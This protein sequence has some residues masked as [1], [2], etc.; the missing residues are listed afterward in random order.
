M[1]DCSTGKQ[2]NWRRI[3]DPFRGSSIFA[4]VA[5]VLASNAVQFSPATAKWR[6][7]QT[8]HF[9]IFYSQAR[10]LDS[11]AEEA[12][13]AYA[14]VSLDL[15]RQVSAKVPLILLPTK[16]DLPQTEVEAAVIVRSSGAAL[17]RD[18]LLLPVEPRT[19]REKMLA[20]ELTHIFEFDRRARHP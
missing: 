13:R 4:V 8:N 1:L 15:G 18:H 2:L 9:D 16:L 17:D 5:L 10:D 3:M 12:E 11:V 14:R 19:G 6:V 7:R 20:H